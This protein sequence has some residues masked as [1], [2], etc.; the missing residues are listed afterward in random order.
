MSA[1]LVV[2]FVMRAAFTFVD[3]AYAA[4]IGDT[5]VAAIGL[6]VPFDFLMIA[7]WVGLSTGLTAALSRTMAAGE[8]EKIEQ[9]LAATWRMAWVVSP[10]FL[11]LGLMIWFAAPQG[12]LSDAVFS[13]FRVYL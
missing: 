2:S 6:T 3:T 12:S 11:A 9:H 10:M 1:P 8:G 13:D 5:A 4:T 7:I